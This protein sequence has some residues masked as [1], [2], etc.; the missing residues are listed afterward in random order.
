MTAFNVQ[1]CVLMQPTKYAINKNNTLITIYK[2]FVP[3]MSLEYFHN[4]SS[5]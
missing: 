3:Y 5:A 1:Q 2:I 4:K